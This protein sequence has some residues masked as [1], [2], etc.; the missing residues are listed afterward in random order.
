MG[1]KSNGWQ[2]REYLLR[3]FSEKRGRAV[4]AYCK[5]MGEGKDQ[6]KQEGLV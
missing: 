5:F 4:R 6:G 1:S 2:E 3:Q